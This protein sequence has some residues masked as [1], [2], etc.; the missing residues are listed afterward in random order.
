M[1]QKT[2]NIGKKALKS[3]LWYTIS[4]IIT[5]CIAVFTTPI[6]TRILTKQDYGTASTFISWYSI[7]SIFC[8]VSLTYSIG[9]AKLDFPGKLKEYIGS[10]Q[11]LS[12]IIT[13]VIIVLNLLFIKPISSFMELS[14]PLV[15]VL[16][17]YLF[18][19]PALQFAQ[20]GFR[21][22]YKYKENIFISIFISVVTV[23]SSFLFIFILKNNASLGRVLGIALPTVI[24]GLFFWFSAIKNKYLNANKQYWKYGLKLSLPLVV[25]TISLNLLAQSDRLLI[26]KY[27]GSEYTAIY[28]LAFSY[29]L[30]INLI[31]GSINEAWLPWFHDTYYI[32]KY[33]EIKTKVKPFIILECMFGIGC[34]ALAPEAIYILGGKGYQG[35]IW[36]VPPIV[37]GI[38][39]QCVYTHYINVQM[40]LKCTKY[41]SIGTLFAAFL[42]IVLNIIFIP[43]FGFVAA[44]YTTLAGYLS[45]LLSHYLI[46]K[47]IMKSDIYDNKF[48]FCSIAVT[49]IIAALFM[50]LFKTIIIRYALLIVLCMVYL[51]LNR[52]FLKSFLSNFVSKFKKS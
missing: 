44:A 3:G 14:V 31:V 27:L 5:K 39:C 48:M 33:D 23:V 7:I 30:L 21:Y 4:N 13:S 45:L 40:T 8:T 35:A 17:V 1:S 28:S 51:F 12:A 52:E 2:E 49:A 26:T 36:A 10:M 50:L 34:I 29:A 24:L 9:R 18:F 6:F 47:L 46:N 37:L 42:N 19:T 15:I 43:R 20:S 38:V 16:L 22:E 25:H 32:K 41:V 11:I